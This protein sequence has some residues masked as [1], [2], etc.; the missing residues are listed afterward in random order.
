MYKHLQNFAIASPWSH[1]IKP[2]YYILRILL[3]ATW[4]AV[5]D[6][7]MPYKQE[8]KKWQQMHVSKSAISKRPKA[9]ILTNQTP[10]VRNQNNTWNRVNKTVPG[11]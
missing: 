3:F 2:S 8:H 5:T 10:H 11:M 1:L 4:I 6:P 9:I 7:Q